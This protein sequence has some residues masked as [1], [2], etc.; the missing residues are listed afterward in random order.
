MDDEG[1]ITRLLECTIIAR[2]NFIEATFVLAR[3]NCS[4]VVLKLG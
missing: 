1:I 2:I 3:L 4:G